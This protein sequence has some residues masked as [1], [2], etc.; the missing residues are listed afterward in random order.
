[1]VLE[2][3]D[4]NKIVSYVKKEP[5][6]VQDVSLLIKKSWVTTDSYLKK[7]K[8]RTGLIN[9]KTFRKGSPAALKIVYYNQAEA[10]LSDEVRDNL[11]SQIRT[12]RTKHDFDFMEVYQFVPDKKKRAFTEKYKEEEISRNQQ[13]ISLFR[14]AKNTVYCLSGNLS[15][16]N[17]KEKKIMLLSVIE[18]LAKRKVMFK[19][20]CRGNIASLRNLN[21]LSK[22]IVKYPKSFE[23]KHC[24]QPLRGFIIDDKIAR[25][26]KEEQLKTYRK[27]ELHQNTR[28]FYEI[29]DEDWIS[30]LQKVFWNLFRSS[31]DCNERLKELK[32]IS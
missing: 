19:I 22:L 7:I 18:E 31:L 17:I 12:G 8:E 10:V 25:F 16:I 30:W 23:I 15:F 4:I 1:M 21:K 9:I 32:K 20:L 6:T 27:G 2:Q 11:F 13:I 28:I 3:A 24:Y 5:R 29:Y 14:Q 26:K